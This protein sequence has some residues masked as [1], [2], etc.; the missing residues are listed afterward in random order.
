MLVF[1]RAGGLQGGGVNFD[2]KIR[3]NSTD[4]ED[5]FHAHI[6]GADVFARA[7]IT[8]EKL[9]K[10]GGFEKMRKSRYA[11]FDEGEGQRFEKG[12]LSL[13]ELSKIAL[14]GKAPERISGKQ[15]LYENILNQYI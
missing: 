14:N 12:A 5:V 8:A 11:S 15:E 3:R 10:D 4:L 9:I 2:A 6:G 7:L 13:E 1:L